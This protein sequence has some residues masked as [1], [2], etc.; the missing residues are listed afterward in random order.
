V[1]DGLLA[2]PNVELSFQIPPGW[3]CMGVLECPADQLE[4]PPEATLRAEGAAVR[5]DPACHELALPDPPQPCCARATHTAIKH[6]KA[7]NARARTRSIGK[8][9]ISKSL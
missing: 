2:A 3:L 1:A 8:D 5:A 6:P 9:L 4:L 7:A